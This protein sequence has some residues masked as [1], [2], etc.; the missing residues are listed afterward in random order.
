[1]TIITCKKSARIRWILEEDWN[2]ISTWWTESDQKRGRRASGPPSYLWPPHEAYTSAIN[3]FTRQYDKDKLRESNVRFYAPERD[4]TRSASLETRLLPFIFTSDPR[5]T[6]L[7]TFLSR[8]PRMTKSETIRSENS[9][10]K[11]FWPLGISFARKSDQKTKRREK[12]KKNKIK[13]VSS[14]ILYSYLCSRIRS[15]FDCFPYAHEARSGDDKSIGDK[16][17]STQQRNKGREN[18]M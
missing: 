18:E 6:L 3:T 8:F 14:N 9:P 16:S 2:R 13:N 17:P 7:L 5:H 10:S 4:N 1:M 12:I 15:N 11:S